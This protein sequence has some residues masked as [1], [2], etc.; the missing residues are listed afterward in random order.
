MRINL[1]GKKL[2]QGMYAVLVSPE[3]IRVLAV[4]E[5]DRAM[6]TAFQ[7]SVEHMINWGP[8]F[9][10][11]YADGVIEIPNGSKLIFKTVGSRR[12]LDSLQGLEIHDCWIDDLH[13]LD[14]ELHDLLASRCRL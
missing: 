13:S 7:T 2:F 1:R 6:K 14:D 5:T 12:D 8:G 11:Y 9:K 4:F 10:A 3:P